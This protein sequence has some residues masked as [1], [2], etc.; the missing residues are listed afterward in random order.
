MLWLS[1]RIV[2]EKQHLISGSEAVRSGF[3][4]EQV[5]NIAFCELSKAMAR[6]LSQ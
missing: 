6:N 5:V 1:R 2:K 4:K 3:F